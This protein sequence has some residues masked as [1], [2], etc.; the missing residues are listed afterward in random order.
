MD[1]AQ[2]N[3][4]VVVLRAGWQ[5]ALENNKQNFLS[6]FVRRGRFVAAFPPSLTPGEFVS[7]LNQNAGNVLSPAE[8]TALIGLFGGAADTGNL[9]ARAQILRQVAESENLFSA[10]FNR[11]FVLMQYVA[12]LRRN[13][14][15]AP[16]ANRDYSGFDFWMKK[17][18]RFNGNFIDA[19]M[20]KAF[21]ES[22]EYQQRFKP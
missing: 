7:K 22:N 19:E 11:A 9:S 1:T 21:V 8:Q 4:E 2:I 5:R 16:E 17:L 13:P 12:Y 10:E 18:N 15:D 20:V 14:D 6:Q 3:Q